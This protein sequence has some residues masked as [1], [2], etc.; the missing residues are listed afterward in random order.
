MTDKEEA[1]FDLLVACLGAFGRDELGG[2]LIETLPAIIGH[3]SPEK[4]EIVQD[5]ITRMVTAVDV[6]LLSAAELKK[7]MSCRH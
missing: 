4:Q 2:I 6:A 1:V 3:G 7:E 5:R